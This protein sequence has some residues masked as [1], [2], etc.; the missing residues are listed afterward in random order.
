MQK[1][2]RNYFQV[3]T[4][5]KTLIIHIKNLEISVIKKE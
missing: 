2:Q 5:I 4:S 3:W 1:L